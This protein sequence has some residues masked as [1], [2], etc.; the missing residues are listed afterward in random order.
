MTPTPAVGDVVALHW[1]RFCDRLTPEQVADLERSTLRELDA[2]NARLQPAPFAPGT[3]SRK[4][5]ERS[6]PA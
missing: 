6:D 3:R 4:P 1:D 5:S 2:T